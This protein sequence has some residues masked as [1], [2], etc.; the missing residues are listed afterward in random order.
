LC[1]SFGLFQAAIA[2][3][4]HLLESLLKNTLIVYHSKDKIAS[5]GGNVINAL[6]SGTAEARANFGGMNLG[7]TINA[8]CRA[9]LITKEEKK[10]LDHLR[11]FMRNAYSHAD[12]EKTFRDGTIP[13]QPVKLDEGKFEVGKREEAKLAELIIGQGIAQAIIA[14]R[15]APKYFLYVDRLARELRGKLFRQQS[16]EAV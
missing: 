10:D 11:E 2:L 13:V 5:D 8:L 14:E 12:K 1:I 15:E 7:N 9:G 4:N 6:V 3:T 16:D